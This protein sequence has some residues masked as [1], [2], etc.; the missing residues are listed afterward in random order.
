MLILHM[1]IDGENIVHGIFNRVSETKFEGKSVLFMHFLKKI[2]SNSN[3][4]KKVNRKW[5]ESPKN[6]FELIQK[7]VMT[8]SRMINT[9]TND[10]STKFFK[11]KK[12]SQGAR[13]NHF[14]FT[15][16]IW[17][18]FFLNFNFHYF[19]AFHLVQLLFASIVFY[20]LENWIRKKEYQII[21][22]E[23]ELRNLYKL[24]CPQITSTSINFKQ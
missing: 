1:H 20:W 3:I 11:L 5:K 22:N 16:L 9:E 23:K 21:F 17:K 24:G 7:F 6:Y 18:N 14:Y 13:K 19:P 15:G 12:K 8:S 10:F 4:F 2:S